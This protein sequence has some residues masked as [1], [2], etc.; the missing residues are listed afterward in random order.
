MV[1]THNEK[2]TLTTK[3]YDMLLR[4]VEKLENIVAI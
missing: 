2:R 3:E 4:R 1:Y